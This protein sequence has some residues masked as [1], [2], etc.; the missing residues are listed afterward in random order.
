MY[1]SEARTGRE[2]QR[3]TTD[4]LR[5]VS[6]GIP[7]DPKTKKVLLITSSKYPNAW[8]LPKGGWENDET[9]EEAAKRETYEEAGVLGE[10]VSFLGNDQDY[11]FNGKPK[12]FYWIYELCVNKIMD[13]WPE[14]ESRQRDWF[15]YDEAIKK[16]ERKSV[17]QNALKKSS[18][19][20]SL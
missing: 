1:P 12:T 16:L 13:T 2:N 6:I 20:S 7:I 5:Q 14:T 19:A 17:L 4:G 11:S 3:Y 10:I 9:Q 15:T 18:I 8:V